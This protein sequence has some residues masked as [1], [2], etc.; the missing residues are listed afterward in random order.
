MPKR[1]AIHYPLKEGNVEPYIKNIYE[2][3]SAGLDLEFGIDLSVMNMLQAYTTG[4]TDAI[5]K[6]V[7]DYN[8]AQ[9]STKAKNELLAKAKKD[10][11]KVL[12][13]I[14]NHS[15]LDESHAETERN[16]LQMVE[17]RNAYLF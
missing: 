11:L 8:T 9:A 1:F 2:K 5:N 13:G 10:I 15:S 4:I 12:R 3:L 17:R 7:K 14:E 16:Y 6:A